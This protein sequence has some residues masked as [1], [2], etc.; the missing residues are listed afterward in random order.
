MKP[1]TKRRVVWLVV[2]VAGAAVLGGALHHFFNSTSSARS[3]NTTSQRQD[4]AGEQNGGIA[5]GDTRGT[6]SAKLGTPNQKKPPCWIYNA[7]HHTVNGMY[8]GETVDAIRYCFA[9]GPAGGTVVSTIYEH[10]IPSAVAQLPKDKRPPG[11]WMHPLI[12]MPKASQHL[13]S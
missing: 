11:G 8:L 7:H 6:V 3:T 4:E 5:Y 9:D 13:K 12:F 2:V 10:L 1:R